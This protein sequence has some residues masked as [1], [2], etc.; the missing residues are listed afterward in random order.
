MSHDIALR[1]TTA[2]ACESTARDPSHE[3]RATKHFAVE[4]ETSRTVL[5]LQ[6][7]GQRRA[8][9]LPALRRGRGEMRLARLA[10]AA[11]HRSGVLHLAKPRHCVV[12]K[13]GGTRVPSAFIQ[14]GATTS[15]TV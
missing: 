5:G 8:H 1:C 3:S 11:G 9:D 15:S 7:R 10:P 6:V 2:A 4:A 12:P 14:C 13:G